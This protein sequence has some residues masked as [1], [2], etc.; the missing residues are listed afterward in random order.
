M[1]WKFNRKG[2]IEEIIKIISWIAFLALL[3]AGV[4]FLIKKIQ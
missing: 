2:E 1:R 3:L 4:Y